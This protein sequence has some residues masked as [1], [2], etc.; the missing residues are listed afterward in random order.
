MLE[1]VQLFGDKF[2]LVLGAR[3]VKVEQDDNKVMLFMLRMTDGC[4]HGCDICKVRLTF[5]GPELTSS[6]V[7]K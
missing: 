4:H 3:V 1:K 2:K 5:S 6:E 7:E